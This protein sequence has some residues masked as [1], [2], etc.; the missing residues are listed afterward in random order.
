MNKSGYR[1]GRFNKCKAIKKTKTTLDLLRAEHMTC[2]LSFSEKYHFG[3]TFRKQV[4]SN[5]GSSSQDIDDGSEQF[6]EVNDQLI[7]L[8]ETN[9]DEFEEEMAATTEKDA[10]VD[11]G[12]PFDLDLINS[13]SS[14]IDQDM[15]NWKS[16]I[17]TDFNSITQHEKNIFFNTT[18]EKPP[19]ENPLN[20]KKTIMSSRILRNK[21][22]LEIFDPEYTLDMNASIYMF[23]KNAINLSEEAVYNTNSILQRYIV[24]LRTFLEFP[25]DKQKVRKILEPERWCNSIN[26]LCMEPIRRAGF[27]IE[28]YAKGLTVYNTFLNWKYVHYLKDNNIKIDFENENVQ[29]YVDF[30][31]TINLYIMVQ[32]LDSPTMLINDVQ[33]FCRK[34]CIGKK[35]GLHNHV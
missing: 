14:H 33:T 10:G 17:P 13:D 1:D 35:N 32:S 2:A 23:W 24:F 19:V 11:G 27:I 6:F 25:D 31:K 8:E 3:M 29:N 16:I 30:L 9:D 20:C 26:K 28:K 18:I 21:K 12:L 5:I 34:T 7:P 22:V 4:S 15:V